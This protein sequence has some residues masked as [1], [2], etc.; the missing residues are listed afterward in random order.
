MNANPISWYTRSIRA[1]LPADAFQPVPSRL[2][3]LA[4]HA[5]VVAAGMGVISARWGGWP[6]WLGMSLLI[7]HSFA[8]LAFVGHELLHGAI[9]RGQRLRHLLGGLCFLPFVMSPRLWVAWH[10]RVHHGHTMVAGVD[11]DAYPTLEAYQNSRLLRFV[12]RFSPAAGRILGWLSLLI[13]FSFQSLHV[14]LRVSQLKGY[15]R[16]GQLL[17]ARLETLLGILAWSALAWW[18]GPL[19]FLFA[20]VIPILLANAVIMVYILTNHSLSPLTEVNDPL[21]NTLSVTT[22]RILSFLHLDFGLHVEHHLFPAMSA[23]H[24]AAVRQVLVRLWPERYQSM[25]F[26]RAIWRLFSTP[27]VYKDPVTLIDPRSGSES[28]TLLPI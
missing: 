13:G 19:A 16:P 20:F 6:V 28:P 3:W 7:G 1:A 22:P 18:L 24:A 27:R 26:G 23:C 21:L 15:L 17:R 14:L 4:L 25:P 8:G 2:V 10:N 12:D 5:A 11:P 9:V